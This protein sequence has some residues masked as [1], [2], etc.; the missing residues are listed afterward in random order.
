VIDLMA[1]DVDDLLEKL[2]GRRVTI[3]GRERVLQTR[4]AAIERVEPTFMTRV[5][6]VLAN[7]NLALLLMMIGVYGIIFELANPGSVAP[8]VIGAVALVLGLYA[9]NQLPLNYAGLALIA[10]GIG[11]MIA[12]AFTPTWGALGIIG[13]ASF[14]FGAAML[15]DTE[16]P[17]YQLSWPLIIGV[18][19]LTGGFV[20][21]VVGFAVRAHRKRVATGAE[22]LIG[23][24]ARVLEWSNGEG[25]VWAEGERWQAEGAPDLRPQQNVRITGVD[26]LRLHVAAEES[27]G[28]T[29]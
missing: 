12:E 25:F 19:I 18:A 15:I 3:A 17:E 28:E 22:G 7:P 1:D 10:L 6:D 23:Q 26:A 8:G 16:L 5:L 14:L 4:G 13:L 2:D 29:R 9:L 20:A 11:L 24:R 27:K 21:L